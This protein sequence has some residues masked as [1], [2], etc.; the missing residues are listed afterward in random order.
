MQRKRTGKLQ[1]GKRSLTAADRH[2]TLKGVARSLELDRCVTG[3]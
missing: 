2:G 1:L 3:V